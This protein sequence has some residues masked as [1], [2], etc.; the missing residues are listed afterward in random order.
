MLKILSA[1]ADTYITNRIISN[2]AKVNA[3]VGC[4]GTL[5]LFKLYGM[6]ATSGVQNTELSRLLV[7][8][9]LEPVK[10]LVSAGLIDITH[11]SFYAKLQMSDV[12][13]G[14]TTPRNYVVNVNPLSMSFDEGVGR[15]ISRYDDV[16]VCNFLTASLS[17]GT[18]ITSGAFAGGTSGCDYYNNYTSQQTFVTGEEDLNVD[19]TSALSATLSSNICD[20]GFRIAFAPTL[21]TDTQTY[22]VKRFASRQ[23]FDTERHPRLV[24]GFDASVQ[25]D[26]GI[27]EL[28]M[29]SSLFMYN[30][31]RGV[32]S[33]IAGVTGDNCTILTLTMPV[34]GG[35]YQLSFSGS[36]YKY[37]S[38]P[39]TGIYTSQVIV[40]STNATINLALQQTGSVTFTPTWS[41]IS[42]GSLLTGSAVTF[43]PL[44]RST[45]P[46]NN[47]NYTVTVTGV[48]NVLDKSQ[49]I[50]VRTNVFDHTSPRI[51][52]VKHPVELPGIVVKDTYY[53]VRD[54]ESSRNTIPFDVEHGSTKLSSDANGM[55]FDLDVSNLLDGHTYVID[56][57]FVNTIERRLFKNASSVFKVNSLG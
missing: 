6:T 42:G 37:G 9:D 43:Y 22:F 41:N 25:D 10:T 15:D 32:P 56:I 39:A 44:Q 8:F 34:S 33:N 45:S 11:P 38:L 23:A 5:D 46:L 2:V 28:D 7:K 51:K 29:T 47:S 48:P 3:N 1:S 14:Q 50:R 27:L 31:P 53:S 55:Y 49:N 36:Q 18:W 20:S 19:V 40:S 13:G 52:L 21:E 54:I 57:M 17:R 4:A 24:V 16:D 12:Y 30:F 26:A 35:F